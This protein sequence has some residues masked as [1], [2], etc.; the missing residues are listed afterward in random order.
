MS[1]D[2]STLSIKISRCHQIIASWTPTGPTS[3]DISRLGGGSSGGAILTIPAVPAVKGC[4]AAG[5]LL[6]A[7]NSRLLT[8]NS[9]QQAWVPGY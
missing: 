3:W 9:R 8:A 7:H 4:T 5:I 1:V 6:P 2:R